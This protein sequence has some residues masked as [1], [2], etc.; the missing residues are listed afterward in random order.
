[1]TEPPLILFT[2][3]SVF[4]LTLL[5][6][7]VYLTWYLWRIPNKL[8]STWLLLGAIAVETLTDLSVFLMASTQQSLL[9]PAHLKGEHLDVVCYSTPAREVGGDLY[10]YHAFR[11]EHNPAEHHYVI[12]VGDVS[13]PLRMTC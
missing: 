12:A 13:D 9:P 8:P 7:D 3:A 2:Y 6:L 5:I 10:A 4:A 11:S 1:M